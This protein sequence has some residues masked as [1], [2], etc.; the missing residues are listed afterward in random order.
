MLGTEITCTTHWYIF[1]GNSLLR[2]V[3]GIKGNNH[4]II[5]NIFEYILFSSPCTHFPVSRLEHCKAIFQQKDMFCGEAQLLI[6]GE[7][8]SKNPIMGAY[9]LLFT[10]QESIIRSKYCFKVNCSCPLFLLSISQNFA[11]WQ[12]IERLHFCTTMKVYTLVRYKL[13]SQ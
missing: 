5:L 7:K 2:S 12:E 4:S 13:T 9:A 8:D 6:N 1:F 10:E 3:G 11:S